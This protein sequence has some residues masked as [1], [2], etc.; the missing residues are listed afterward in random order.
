MTTLPK[1]TITWGAAP[2]LTWLAASPKVTSR[3]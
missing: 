2:L 3:T 1:A